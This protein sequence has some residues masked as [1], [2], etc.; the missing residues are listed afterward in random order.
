MGCEFRL[1]NR[2]APIPERKCLKRLE[3]YR[4]ATRGSNLAG[5]QGVF[6]AVFRNPNKDRRFQHNWHDVSELAISNFF[7]DSRL[8]A[9]VF[10]FCQRN[11]TRN[12]TRPER[13]PS[14]SRRKPALAK[15]HHR[16]SVNTYAV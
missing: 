11:D 16:G 12:D 14:S 1:R 7:V 5:R 4:S 2:I 10:G 13:L 9:S 15:P 3:F 8:L 6:T